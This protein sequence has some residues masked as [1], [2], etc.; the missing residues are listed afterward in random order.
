MVAVVFAVLLSAT[1]NK[2]SDPGWEAQWRKA[3]SLIT[4][5]DYEGALPILEALESHPEIPPGRRVEI[6]LELGVA[7]VNVG[8]T[9]RARS[10]FA[11][12]VEFDPTAALPSLAPPK[13]LSL[14]ESV[15]PVIATPP[16]DPP[17]TD[18]PKAE[19]PVPKLE[20]RPSPVAVV[21]PERRHFTTP[22]VV[23]GLLAIA[24]ATAGVLMALQS[25][26]LARELAVTPRPASEVTAALGQ[27]TGFSIGSIAG[28]GAAGVFAALSVFFFVSGE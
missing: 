5:L 14:L 3:S 11:K 20:P 6:L 10:A 4:K 17:P 9:E 24:T 16:Q 27:R 21:Q 1:P 23:T 18:V 25:Q 2:R 12:A 13:A 22:A 19:P 26:Q 7:Y 15:R 28:Y 8:R